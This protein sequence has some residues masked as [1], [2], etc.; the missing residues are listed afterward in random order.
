[1]IVKTVGEL[2]D[3][4]VTTNVKIFFLMERETNES[5]SVEERFK[6]GQHVIALNKKRKRLLTAIDEALG[7][8]VDYDPKTY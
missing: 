1:M 7:Q 5:L 3:S 6:A 8:E 4:L 2:I